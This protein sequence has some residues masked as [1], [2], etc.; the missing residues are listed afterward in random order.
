MKVEYF[1]VLDKSRVRITG[2]SGE[3]KN[4]EPLKNETLHLSFPFLPGKAKVTC[5]WPLAVMCNDSVSSELRFYA[6]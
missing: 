2:L 1:K 5:S 3:N 6:Y 4:L